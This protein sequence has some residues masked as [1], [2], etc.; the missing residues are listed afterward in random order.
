MAA[1]VPFLLSPAVESPR[2]YRASILNRK[3]PINANQDLL[4]DLFPAEGFVWQAMRLGER[5]QTLCTVNGTPLLVS[6]RPP[7]HL[8]RSKR[9][10]HESRRCTVRAPAP[11]LRLNWAQPT[12]SR[13]RR[14]CRLRPLAVLLTI[15]LS[16]TNQACSC[17]PRMQHPLAPPPIRQFGQ[18]PYLAAG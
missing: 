10:A 5:L 6:T 12:R 11:S 8:P 14:I 13:I 3:T 18:P 9:S 4:V 2:T 15:L 7:S 17:P 1:A 16:R